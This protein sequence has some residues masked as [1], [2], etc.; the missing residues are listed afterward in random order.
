[1]KGQLEDLRSEVVVIG[2]G[3]AGVSS[4]WSLAKAGVPVVLCE[5]GRIAGE[6]S[7]RNWGWIR[8]QGRDPR[9]LP[10]SVLALRLWEQI[11]GEIGEDIGWY[12]GGVTYLAET[13]DQLGHFEA[14]LSHARDHQLDSR[15]LSPAETDAL[16]GQSGRRFKGALFTPSDAR[17]EPTR[18]V[19][20]LARAAERAGATILEGCAAR[21]LDTE[22]G[23]VS[24]VLTERGPISCR[25]VILAAGAW[26]A[27]F[28]R[29]LGVDL[30]QLKVK[31]S[32]QRTTAAA[33]ITQSA[34]GAK[35]ASF[36]R[37]QDGGYTIA[38]S[39]ATTFDITPAAFRHF[40][41][42]L[43]ALRANWGNSRLRVGLPFVQELTTS[44]RWAADQPTPFER[45]R[46][47][48]PPPDHGVLDRVLRDAAALFPQL[49]GVRPVERWAGMI[50]VTPDEIPVLGAVDGWSGLFV[51]TGFSGHGFGIGPAAG[52]LMAQLA[53]G[54]QPVVDLA[55]F[56]LA[57][58]AE[59]SVRRYP[60]GT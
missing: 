51:A 16:L 42:F 23:K 39:G 12:K 11:A 37:R 58:F 49:E 28:L 38:R 18:A 55:P 26:C 13:P 14:W 44:V 34:V 41:A 19:P 45:H 3:V 47:L 56:R 27:L 35:L 29:H 43:P 50:D 22:A 48:D 17:A 57:R 9:E 40:R 1:M 52:Y 7:S 36:R 54:E 20:A 60:A 30:P 24:H 5:K 46:V 33:L 25:A 10:A 4:A 8:K 2:G 6:Q 59:G 53:R 31:A 21:S 15:L 32:V